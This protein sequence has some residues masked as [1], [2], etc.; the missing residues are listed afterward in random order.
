MK[1]NFMRRMVFS[2]F[3][4]IAFSCS[5]SRIQNEEPWWPQTQI[6]LP[7]VLSFDQV[8]REQYSNSFKGPVFR[9]IY[10]FG[11][12]V[13][14]NNQRKPTHLEVAVG[15]IRNVPNSFLRRQLIYRRV[16]QDDIT[17]VMRGDYFL[18]R[19]PEENRSLAENP[20]GPHFEGTILR[21]CHQVD[22]KIAQGAAEETFKF[23]VALDTWQWGE[24]HE[25]IP[26]NLTEF[27]H[28]FEVAFSA[29]EV[30]TKIQQ[31]QV[32]DFVLNFEYIPTNDTITISLAEH[33]EIFGLVDEKKNKDVYE[34][35]IT[36]SAT[37]IENLAHKTFIVVMTE[38]PTVRG[39][40]K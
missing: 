13:I 21:G 6:D 27:L 1:T 16:W 37:E 11:P 7:E 17:H 20:W 3:L 12:S 25:T 32:Y 9:E 36:I 39:N 4:L 40:A 5:A 28:N 29:L 34:G 35:P 10:N 8:F 14:F 19:T 30:R 31:A 18:Q 15:L 22:P 26:R 38:I 33:N 2:A 24:K 23:I